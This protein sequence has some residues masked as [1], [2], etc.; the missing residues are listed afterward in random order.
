MLRKSESLLKTLA[1]QK[2]NDAEDDAEGLENVHTLVMTF[3]F[4]Y[5]I[6]YWP[7]SK[8]EF[9]RAVA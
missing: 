5:N 2:Q 8:A 9:F 6:H 7:C 1:P 3:T 4:A